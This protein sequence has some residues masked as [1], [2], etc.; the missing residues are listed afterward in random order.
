MTLM[1]QVSNRLDDKAK[2]ESEVIRYKFL[3][4]EKDN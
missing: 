2:L 4:T 3:F 1:N